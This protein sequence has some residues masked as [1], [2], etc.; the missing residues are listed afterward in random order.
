MEPKYITFV[1]DFSGILFLT[2]FF[3]IIVL[4][5]YVYVQYNLFWPTRKITWRP[6][7]PYQEE[8]VDG[9]MIWKLMNHPGKDVILY[10]HGNAGNLG[11][12]KYMVD[13]C[14]TL[15]LNLVLFDYHG[16]GE[17]LHYPT[18]HGICNNGATVYLHLVQNLGID[19]ERI[20]I[21][22]I[23]L[24]SSCAISIASKFPCKALIV[25]SAFSSLP[26]IMDKP[27]AT[28]IA[29]GLAP[30]L[31]Y[32]VDDIPS[33]KRIKDVKCP[34]F[35]IHS[36]EDEL[37]PYHNGVK[38][39]RACRHKESYDKGKENGESK[40]M[41]ITIAGEHSKPKLTVEHIRKMLDFCDLD[42]SNV[43]NVSDILKEISERSP[44]NLEDI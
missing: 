11:H 28:G 22:G 43:E 27:G 29:K 21:W 14:D 3:F 1:Q 8:M 24:G 31:T 39:F 13:I 41:F 15:K 20:V 44:I 17:S 12:N 32:I 9:V 26:D 2:L 18:A 5:V 10:C 6:T 35:V 42:G 38:L 33:A 37:I 19:P 25:M 36:S 16:F 34:V 40:K 23:S 7:I 30:A 4:V